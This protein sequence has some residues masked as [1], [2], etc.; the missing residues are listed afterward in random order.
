MTRRLILSSLTFAFSLGLLGCGSATSQSSL[1]GKITLDSQPLSKV[2]VVA[3]G[4][5][6]TD[7]GGSSDEQ[8]NYEIIDPPLGQIKLQV[9]EPPE[10]SMGKPKPALAKTMAPG[11]GVPYEMKAGNQKFDITLSSK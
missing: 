5:A 10:R 4:P 6:G 7:K 9:I 2:L 1:K 3:K 8:G 11:G